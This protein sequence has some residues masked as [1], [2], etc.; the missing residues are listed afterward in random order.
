MKIGITCYPTHGGSGVIASELALGLA[1]GGH[2]IHIV[3][4]ATPFRLRSFHQNVFIHEVE[5]TSYPLFK[6]PPYALSLATKL[7]DVAREYGLDLIHAHYAVPHAASAYL[8]KEIL[9]SKRLK[10]ITTLHGTDITL[11]GTDKSFYQVIKFTI[12]ESDGVTAVSR[13]LQ[14][15]TIDEFDIRREIRVIPNFVDTGRYKWDSSNCTR[16]HFAP[17]GEKILMHAS[18]FRPVKRVTDVVRIFARVREQ[19]PVK[20]LLVGEGPERLF[21]QQLVKELKLSDDVLFLGEQDYL[22]KLMSCADLFILPSEQESFG[23]VAL[24][25]HSCG[26]PVIGTPVGGLPEVVADGETGFLL[27]VGDIAGMSTKAAELLTN[28]ELYGAFQKHGRERAVRCFDS[29]LIIPRY[30]AFYEE[31]LNS[32]QHSS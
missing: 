26:V 31:I 17:K 19:M 15:R 10:T 12:E 7:V 32:T 14:K 23:L 13:Y 6:Y 5:V 16:E 29:Q 18:N 22:E 3:S 20:L 21:V 24:E 28:S 9:R 27:P 8:A 4:Y 30:Q 1:Q 2:E 11:V 25:A